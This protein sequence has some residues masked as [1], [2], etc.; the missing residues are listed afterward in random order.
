MSEPAILLLFVEDDELIREVVEPT[1]AD[2][3]YAVITATRS[4]EA[5]VL[6]T[7]RRAEFCGL[8]TDINLGD[9]PNG[10]EVARVARQLIADIPVVYASGGSAHG[11]PAEGVPG[12]LMV[13]KPY[14]PEQIVTA[15]ERLLNS[16]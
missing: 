8:V 6:L 15:M 4:E 1:L 12:S 7:A 2:A 5:V 13:T 11:F 9:G 14:E 16:G 3:G 10:W